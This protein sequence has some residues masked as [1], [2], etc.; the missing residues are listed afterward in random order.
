MTVTVHLLF[1]GSLAPATAAACLTDE[2]MAR[3]AR[4]RFPDD[5]ARWIDCRASLRMILGKALRLLPCEVPLMLTE[6]GK[7]LLLSPHDGLHFNLSHCADR[8]LVALSVDGPVGIDLEPLERAPDL[9]ECTATFCHP[10]EIIDLPDESHARATALLHIWTAKEA[11]LKA[12]GTG[13]SHPPDSVRI[14]FQQGAG[15]AISEPPLDGLNRQRLRELEHPGLA[16]YQAMLS[17]PQSVTVIR[18]I[19]GI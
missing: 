10:L 4:F 7:P 3:A 14:I 16:G 18:F 6:F 17:V 8:A 1:P 19:E 5:A 13:L 2:E 9:L 15:I 12:L 11:V